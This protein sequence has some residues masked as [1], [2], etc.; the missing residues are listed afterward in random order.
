[1]VDSLLTEFLE[2]LVKQQQKLL[3]LHKFMQDLY[4]AE[5]DFYKIYNYLAE[6][7]NLEKMLNR[8]AVKNIRTC[9]KSSRYAQL[10]IQFLIMRNVQIL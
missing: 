9:K 5:D 10:E 2:N 4:V 7:E 3:E 1:M 8:G 6:F